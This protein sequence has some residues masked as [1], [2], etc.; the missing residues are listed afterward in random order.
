MILYWNK[1]AIEE[2]ISNINSFKIF[3][4]NKSAKEFVVN[5]NEDDYYKFGSPGTYE[6]CDLDLN[7]MRLTYRKYAGCNEYEYLHLSMDINNFGE[8]K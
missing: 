8:K 4:L 3:I 7:N 5:D 6:L 1:E 2:F